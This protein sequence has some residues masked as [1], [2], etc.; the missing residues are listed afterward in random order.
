MAKAQCDR[1]VRG[2]DAFVTIDEND[3]GDGHEGRLRQRA[4]QVCE[5][6]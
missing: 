3:V 4:L 6:M 1:R 5:P 2:T